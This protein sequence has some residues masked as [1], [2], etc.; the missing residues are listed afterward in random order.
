MRL[1]RIGSSEF[2]LALASFLGV[3]LVGVIEGVFLAVALSLLAF[4]RRAWWPHDAVL[5]RADGVKGYHDLTYY[6]EAR[7]VPG[8]APVP[9][10]CPA[11]LRQRRRLPRPRARAD[12]RP[13]DRR[14]AGSI[15]AAEP[16]TDVDTT[17]A[18]MLDRLAEE[19][20]RRGITLAFA[21]L[22]DPVR[23]RLRRYGALERR[24]RGPCLPD[25]RHGRQRLRPGV[26]RAVDRL[27]GGRAERRRLLASRPDR[28]DDRRQD[29]VQVADHRVGRAG[30]HRR[31]AVRVDG[32]DRLGRAGSRPC[33][34]SPR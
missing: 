30:H 18:A 9:V 17:A 27:G 21:E 15:V 10:R 22:K 3:A 12:R 32:Q 28:R 14:S 25:R 5:G 33:A 13:R 20:R 16:I 4:I 8:L 31:V 2:W 24:A 1:W 34:G 29:G 19:L 26:R 11:V 23:D 7:Q 6:P